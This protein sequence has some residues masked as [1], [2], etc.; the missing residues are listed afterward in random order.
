ME[1]VYTVVE[2][3][4]EM[5]THHLAYKLLRNAEKVAKMMNKIY[6]NQ[7]YV[8]SATFPKWY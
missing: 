6:G 1:Y 8:V 3:G 7:Y 2:K 5:E 4:R